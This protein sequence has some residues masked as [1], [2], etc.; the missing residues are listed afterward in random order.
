V[1]LR[2]GVDPHIWREEKVGELG[3]VGVRQS[4]SFTYSVQSLAQI[5]II[6]EKVKFVNWTALPRFMIG[7]SPAAILLTGELVKLSDGKVIV[8]VTVRV[9]TYV[10]TV[11]RAM[12]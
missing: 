11:E 12:V 2:P 9:C 7:A 3:G 5:R 10:V 8:T 6:N 4:K 1:G